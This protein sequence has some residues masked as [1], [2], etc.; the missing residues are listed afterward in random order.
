M[1]WFNTNDRDIKTDMPY[2]FWG[3]PKANQYLVRVD[4]RGLPCQAQ[5][6]S[7][8]GFGIQSSSRLQCQTRSDKSVGCRIAQYGK[9]CS[10]KVEKLAT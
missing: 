4:A 8:K 2:M 9:V 3:L 5:E 10:W 1:H 7:Q 6:L